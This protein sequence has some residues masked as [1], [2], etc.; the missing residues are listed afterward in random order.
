MQIPVPGQCVIVRKRPAIVR[1]LDE[2][3]TIKDGFI[4]HL[5]EVE[6]IDEH[7][8]PR[9]DKL[10]WERELDAKVF[11]SFKF[12]DIGNINLKPDT[13]ERYKRFIDA[14]KWTSQGFYSYQNDSVTYNPTN[15]VSPS[16][17]SVQVEDYQLFPVLK[18]LTMPRANLLLADDVGLGKTIEAGLI[19]QELIRNK[20][21]RRIII[22]CPSALQ[23][24]WQDEM[25]EKFNIDF[26]ILDTA[27]IFKMQRELGM[28]ANPWKIYPRIIIS[29]DYLKQKDILN[30]F[31][32]TSQQLNP[33]D[34]AMLP[35]DLLIVDEA[36]NLS[37]SRF[38]DESL[39]CSMLREVSMYCEN[40]LFL[41]AT[42][43]NGYTVSFTGLLEMLDPI[44]FQQK[45]VLDEEDMSNIS[46]IMIR[47]MKDDLNKGEIQRFPNRFI[48]GLPIELSQKE[49]QLYDALREY[50]VG[51]TRSISKFGKK[52]RIIAGFIF[53]ILT[54]RLL[55]STYSFAKTW[56]NHVESTGLEEF[57]IN[58]A[59]ESMKRAKAPIEDDTEKSQR[60]MDAVRHGGSWLS[61]Y[62]DL[63]SPYQKRISEHLESMGWSKRIIDQEINESKKLPTDSKFDE[64]Y[65]W[66]QKY[67]MINKK[68]L[69]DERVIIF[70]EYKNTLDY[71]VA[72]F[73]S[74]GITEPQL[75]TLF[76]G[77]AAEQRRKIKNAFNDSAS[78]LRIL[79]A[80]EVAAEGLNLQQSCRY[81][82]HQEIPW[83]PMRLEQRNGRVDRHG[84]SRDVTIFHF[85]SD[86]V[87]EL[88]FLDFV[89][90]KVHRVRQDL[91]S[92]GKV[93]DE[94]V[95]EYFTKGTVTS[96]EVQK[97][98]EITQR[99]ADNSSDTSSADSGS[100]SKYSGAIKQYSQTMRNLGINE[101]SFARVLNQAMIL[102]GG[103]IKEKGD[104]SYIITKTPPRWK[105]LIENTILISNNSKRGA[106]PKLVF[107]PDRVQEEINGRMIFQPGK[108]T[109]LLMLGHP[110]MQ[111]ALS[112]FKRRMWISQKNSGMN[113]WTVE[114]GKLTDNLDAV[115]ILTYEISLRN[116]LGERFQTGILEIP[117]GCN[118]GIKPISEAYFEEMK[119]NSDDIHEISES[120]VV[121]HK[122]IISKWNH[123]SQYSKELIASIEDSLKDSVKE[124][125]EI[126]FKKERK[127]QMKLFAERRSSLEFKKDE[128]SLQ[129]LKTEMLTAAEKVRQLTFD[130]EENLIRKE[131]Y[132]NL[133]L[134]ITE[135]E[136][137]R[138][139]SHRE[140][141][142]ERLD[143]EEKRIIEKV[144]PGRY[145]LDEDG[146]EIHPVGVHV[147]LREGVF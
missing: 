17:S 107:S 24:Q 6:Y 28:D 113:K 100:A 8:Y 112:I 19:T 129:K 109:R 25:K 93:L 138:Q 140:K 41:S 14:I 13:P 27:Q 86:Q 141:L 110:V 90:S 49:V 96:K 7:D 87:D 4:Q 52:E 12:P 125:L 66:I 97:R 46:Q 130:E 73:K 11:A 124:N 23:I 136:W 119:I 31:I 57:G 35:W 135:A 134:R 121:A 143:K 146:I 92:V 61:N 98:I 48:Q 37:P 38:A 50:R 65:D 76:G 102:E 111:K 60:E 94:T 36:H 54:K 122:F 3:S 69:A 117:L 40:H 83:N 45:A 47:R 128:R 53:S 21:I 127:E 42:P 62:R 123:V 15:L 101:E 74:K 81:V 116:K 89:V 88:K 114:S 39:R 77:S 2:N 72:K 80:T 51:V 55:S 142:K 58:E 56:W 70:T 106:Q 30:K 20:K 147:I 103:E 5:I 18:A 33:K 78:P 59:N 82:I 71:L 67:L 84:Q 139:H 79:I 64:L 104:R 68:F 75:Q 137:E 95:I 91:G 118:N 105:N 131:E 85:V 126:E 34:S 9:E 16:F 1:E 26:T 120:V 115:F 145:S 132:D 99:V 108:D 29:M 32:H 144:L 22:I 63:V 44:R 10:I 43:H 133:K